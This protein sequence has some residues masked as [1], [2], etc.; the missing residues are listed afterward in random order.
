M[1]IGSALQAVGLSPLVAFVAAVVVD[2][3]FGIALALK[4]KTFDLKKLPSF[5]ES[6]FGT[7]EF[8]V[9]ATAAVAAYVSGGDVKAA[10]TA[11]V[12]AGGSALFLSVLKDIYAKALAFVGKAPAAKASAAAKK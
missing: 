1:D 5:L 4:A 12:V 9:V 7:K 6:Q 8:L 11:V 2:D 3:V 10:A